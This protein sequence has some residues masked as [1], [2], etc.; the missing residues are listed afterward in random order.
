MALIER[1][2][3]GEGE[4]RVGEEGVMDGREGER[5]IGYGKGERERGEKKGR[6]GRG[7]EGVEKGREWGLGGKRMDEER[8]IGWEGGERNGGREEKRGQVRENGREGGGRNYQKEG[9]SE[10][11]CWREAGERD[12]RRRK[13]RLGKRV[14]VDGGKGRRARWKRERG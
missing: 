7:E 8:R 13:G 3:G 9:G 1:D 4:G 2:G 5:R 11:D 12:R 6:M 14:W 10:D